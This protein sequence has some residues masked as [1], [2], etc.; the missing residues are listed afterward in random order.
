M[1][2]ERAA[3]I[4]PARLPCVLAIGAQ[5]VAGCAAFL[6]HMA[7]LACETTNE[8]PGSQETHGLIRHSARATCR[9]GRTRHETGGSVSLQLD[10]LLE[11]ALELAALVALRDRATL[12]VR[13][14]AAGDSELE[15][16]PAVTDV[17]PQRHQRLSL[18]LGQPHQLGDLVL[19][20]EELS[21][22]P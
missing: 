17:E 13:L 11:L 3:G 10:P 16:G 12:V 22:A 6:R 18:G 2:S 4:R 21:G 1:R 14:L 19:V 9:C 20:E 7:S 5:P 15:L 8:V